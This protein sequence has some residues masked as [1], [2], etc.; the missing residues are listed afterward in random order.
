MSPEVPH[1]WNEF[2]KTVQIIRARSDLAQ[3]LQHHYEKCRTASHLWT[4][5]HKVLTDGLPQ[6]LNN[7]RILQEQ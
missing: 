5:Q 1:V 3:L 6:Y 4:M 7:N 2:R